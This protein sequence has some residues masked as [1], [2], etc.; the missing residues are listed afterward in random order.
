[1]SGR[2]QDARIAPCA[3]L[4]AETRLG[5][6]RLAA[7]PDD[8]R[9]R[10]EAE[11][12]AVQLAVHEQLTA[13]G[14]GARA[15]WKIGCTTAVMRQFLKID[16]PCAGGILASGLFA[17]P[18][19]FAFAGLRKPGIECEIAVRLGADLP[20]SGAP[21]AAEDLGDAVAA[22]MPAIE[23]VEERFVDF[24][25][26][27]VDAAS[28]IADDFFHVAA[29]VGPE[30]SDWRSLD[31]AA[32]TGETRIDGELR[33]Q[34]RGA[35]VMGHPLAALAW[36]ADHLAGLGLALRRGD[37]VLT[38]SVVVTQYPGGPATVVT[39]IDRLGQVELRLT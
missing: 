19:T 8:V 17:A 23:L 28:L 32:L 37:V 24:R 10:S 34:G 31:L 20:A 5:R 16:Q 27:A 13:A 1:M 3:G 30:T 4:L 35:D 12:Y 2:G 14:R 29:I 26:P 18:A 9:P 39:E 22:V 21:Y 11:A 36:L 38:G 6:D 25:D 33:G 15:G 7:L